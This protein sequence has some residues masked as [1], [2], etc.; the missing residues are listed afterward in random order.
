MRKANPKKWTF[1]AL[2]EFMQNDSTFKMS[3]FNLSE[4][5]VKRDPS[6][7]KKRPKSTPKPKMYN[8]QCAYC[9]Q[10]FKSKS[11][12]TEVCFDKDCRQLLE[13]ELNYEKA[14]R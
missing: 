13:D 2:V 4:A 14:M 12:Y 3:K 8:R 7:S 1:K 5:M 6:L 10:P 11:R 9:E